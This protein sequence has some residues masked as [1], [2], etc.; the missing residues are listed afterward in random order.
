MTRFVY[1][2]Q[3]NEATSDSLRY[4]KANTTLKSSLPVPLEVLSSALPWQ[5]QM[6]ANSQTATR[7]IF[8]EANL[9][10]AVSRLMCQLPFCI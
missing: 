5:V 1:G 2:T 6:G 9:L 7:H 4:E 8:T 10:A 3:G